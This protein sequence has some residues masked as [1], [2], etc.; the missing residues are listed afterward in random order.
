MIFTKTEQELIKT[1]KGLIQ[2]AQKYLDQSQFALDNDSLYT[3]RSKS[4]QLSSQ[5]YCQVDSYINSHK[6]SSDLEKTLMDLRRECFLLY[7]SVP[8]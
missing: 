1:V 4:K 6:L 3:L 7:N 5:A 2:K 8:F